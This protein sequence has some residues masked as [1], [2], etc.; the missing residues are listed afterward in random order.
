MA[1]MN[2][3]LLKEVEAGADEITQL[4]MKAA[5]RAARSKLQLLPCA[6][7]NAAAAR[8][9]PANKPAFRP[10][11]SAPLKPWP[12]P[13]SISRVLR[14]SRPGSAATAAEPVTFLVPHWWVVS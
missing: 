2:D 4:K 8:S 1:A 7:F 6:S 3:R 14:I 13:C 5:R 12:M 9:T 11:P 10:Y